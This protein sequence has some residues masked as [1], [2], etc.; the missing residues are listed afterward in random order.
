MFTLH[1][2]KK[3]HYVPLIFFFCCQ[4]KRCFKPKRVVIDFEVIIHKAVGNVWPN[5]TVIC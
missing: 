1:G 4:T 5:V 2:Y 3:G